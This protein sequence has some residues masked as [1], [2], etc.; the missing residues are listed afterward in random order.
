MDLQE[1][2][3]EELAEVYRRHFQAASYAEGNRALEEAEAL[4]TRLAEEY[5]EAYARQVDR[6]AYA[7]GH[8]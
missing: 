7:I 4:Q 5:G 2:H 3:V 6:R 8:G 1:R